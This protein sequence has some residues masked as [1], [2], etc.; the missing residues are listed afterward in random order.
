M[1]RF[2]SVFCPIFFLF[3]L[4]LA[5]MLPCSAAENLIQDATFT[6]TFKTSSNPAYIIWG[7]KDPSSG[8]LD[9]A[10]HWNYSTTAADGTTP[11]K[12]GYYF[13]G[14]GWFGGT[15]SAGNTIGL[16][17]FKGEGIANVSQTV[18]GLD[19]SRLYL[20]SYEFNV[21]NDGGTPNAII[22]SSIDGIE[23]QPQ[24]TIE[25]K[26]SYQSFSKVFTPTADSMT[27]TFSNT[28][29]TGSGTDLDR[30]LGIANV[31]LSLAP[32]QKVTNLVRD[33]S[34][35]TGTYGNGY[36]VN[37]AGST[38]NPRYANMES[39]GIWTTETVGVQESGKSCG[40]YARPT[41]TNGYSWMFG[42]SSVTL[43][44]GNAAAGIQN[45]QANGG[46]TCTLQQTLALEAGRYY[47]VSYACNGREN[48]VGVPQTLSVSVHDANGSDSVLLAPTQ[49]ASNKT[50]TRKNASFL[51][52][53]DS[54]SL[55]FSNITD[56]AIDSTL[57]IDDVRVTAL[58]TAP[59]AAGMTPVR[60][61]DLTTCLT[62][63]YKNSVPYAY[64]ASSSLKSENAIFDRIGYYLEL[65][66][67]SGKTQTCFITMDAFTLDPTQ[68]GLHTQS[69][70][71]KSVKNL[72]V[73]SSVTGISRTIDR[74]S[75]EFFSSDYVTGPDG[76]YDCIDN[77]FSNSKGHGSFQ[78]HDTAA[79]TDPSGL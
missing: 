62:T 72:E 21:R 69:S 13:R 57:V 79:K 11:S 73:N 54:V 66:D 1:N 18:S 34:F 61:L 44:D 24:T 63:A 20:V 52:A 8:T 30:S 50:F 48:R 39:T 55:R 22:S 65:M 6:G 35:E 60:A 7:A 56:S 23:L 9:T 78:I 41:V 33:G 27:L 29:P 58:P 37:G 43:P 5:E 25:R 76:K 36:I 2:F 31:N 40:Y 28:N 4:L 74:G 10:G 15:P 47:A 17:N 26:G 38:A 45:Y 67:G 59:M 53:T 68:I 49:I 3:F 32:L 70:L 71:A 12:I 77:G 51:A 14:N 16:Q 64:D 42:G 75:I 46:G 19:A